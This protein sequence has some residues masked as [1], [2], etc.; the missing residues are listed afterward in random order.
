MFLPGIGGAAIA[1]FLERRTGRFSTTD[2][3]RLRLIYPAILG[4]HK[5]HLSRLFLTLASDVG[6]A[7]WPETPGAVLLVDRTGKRVFVNQAWRDAEAANPELERAIGDL[8]PG[9]CDRV[10]LAGGA[11]LH[12]EPLDADFPLAPNGK[13]HVLEVS[14]RRPIAFDYGQ[15]VARFLPPE[16][17]PR[18]REIVRLILASRSTEAIAK[19]LGIGKGTV[20]NHRRRLYYKLDI[21]SERELFALF[22]DYLAGTDKRLS[23]APDKPREE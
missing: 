19:S 5:A 18:E 8:S 15:A 14:G 9:H 7:S 12:V 11:M 20:K 13:M 3:A 17:T 4:L 21:T 1:L 6:G 23:P 22:L 16:L 2:V 10:A